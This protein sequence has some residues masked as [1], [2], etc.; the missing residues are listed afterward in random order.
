MNQTTELLLIELI[1]RK[2]INH[3]TAK[4]LPNHYQYPSGSLRKATVN[5]ITFQLD[6]HNWNDWEVY[7]YAHG[8]P[9]DKLIRLCKVD[10]CVIDIG[11]NIGFVVM[12]MAL[13][14]GPKGKAY[15]FEPNPITFEKMMGN[16]RL[17]NFSNITVT[18]AALGNMEGVVEPVTVVENNL[19]RSTVK[20]VPNS[21]HNFTSPIFTLDSFCERIGLSHLNIVKIDVEGYEQKVLLGGI[22]TIEKFRPILFIEIS[23][24]NLQQQDSSPTEI[25]TLLNQ[26]GYSFLRAH[27]NLVITPEYSFDEDCHF[28]VICYPK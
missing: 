9:I 5:G 3:W 14:I 23:Y 16:L 28:D 21:Q 17:N 6:I 4:L 25:F 10:D 15:G 24:E 7:F 2:G 18:Q 27:D 22:K 26:F 20:V 19:G 1:K 8:E 12:N 11:S 13:Q